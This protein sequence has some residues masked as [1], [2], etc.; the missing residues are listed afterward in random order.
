MNAILTAALTALYPALRRILPL[1]F[2]AAVLHVLGAPAILPRILM[3]II[4]AL[5]WAHWGF[6]LDLLD[7]PTQPG[8]TS[9]EWVRRLTPHQQD[10][11]LA[12]W[13]SRAGCMGMGVVALIWILI[14]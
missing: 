9:T 12:L 11:L 3:A 14:P 2:G 4:A 8:E 6:L 13:F 5:A 1:I 7:L 10:A